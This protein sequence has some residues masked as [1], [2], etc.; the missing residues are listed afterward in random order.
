[1]GN[2]EEKKALGRPRQ[3]Y[4]INIKIDVTDIG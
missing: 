2:P 4:E 1:V 3:K